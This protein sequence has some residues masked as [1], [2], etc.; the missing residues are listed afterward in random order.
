MIRAERIGRC[1]LTAAGHAGYARAGQ[2]IVCAAVSALVETLEAYLLLLQMEGAGETQING[3][4]VAFLPADENDGRGAFAFDYAETGLRLI[5][6]QY[7]NHVSFSS[8][9]CGED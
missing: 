7:P 8:S 6:K 3:D 5:E 9:W 2:D 4:R 1:C